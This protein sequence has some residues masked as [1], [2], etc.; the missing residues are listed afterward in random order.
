MGVYGD[1]QTITEHLLF[2]LNECSKKL[3]RFRWNSD[4]TREIRSPSLAQIGKSTDFHELILLCSEH[5]P[6]IV[7]PILQSALSRC[8]ESER[9]HREFQVSKKREAEAQIGPDNHKQARLPRSRKDVF[10]AGSGHAPQLDEGKKCEPRVHQ[11][12]LVSNVT[13]AVT[14]SHDRDTIDGSNCVLPNSASGASDP[15]VPSKIVEVCQSR[16]NTVGEHCVPDM[17]QGC[18]S[19]PQMSQE[20]SQI[21]TTDSMV[22]TAYEMELG[23]VRGEKEIQKLIMDKCMNL[24]PSCRGTKWFSK[25]NELQA[26][27]HICRK[28]PARIVKAW[29]LRELESRIEVP[30]NRTEIPSTANMSNPSEILDALQCIKMTT[31]NSKIHRA[32]GQMRLFE[33]VK[34]IIKAGKTPIDYLGRGL[35]DHRTILEKAACRAAGKVSEK[36]RRDREN[37]FYSEYGAGEKWLDVCDWFGGPGIVLIF[38]TTGVS[39]RKLVPSVPTLERN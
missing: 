29:L 9:Q 35:S 37:H 10:R 6:S 15:S 18:V 11:K 28:L 39:N 20:S 19:A 2:D 1:E 24:S 13:P 14:E 38:V 12:D 4:H 16:E 7:K 30:G 26:M 17:G 34:G 36:E 27:F 22:P 21:G 3:G 33:S 8:T 31:I 5:S 23:L 25:Q 32:Y